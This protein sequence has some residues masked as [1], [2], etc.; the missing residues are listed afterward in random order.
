MPTDML[1]GVAT[2]GG[3]KTFESGFLSPSVNRTGGLCCLE[4]TVILTAYDDVAGRVHHEGV[5]AGVLTRAASGRYPQQSWDCIGGH[6][7]VP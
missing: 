3:V 5:G 4:L 1:D 2:S 6:F 7:T